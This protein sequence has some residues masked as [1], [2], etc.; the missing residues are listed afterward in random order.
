MSVQS[1]SLNFFN[2]I[3]P[4]TAQAASAPQGANVSNPIKSDCVYE[5]GSLLP[6]NLANVVQIRTQ[7]ESEDEMK[8]YYYIISALA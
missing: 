5:K 4:K 3:R 7:L 2:K 8:M 1:S 6:Y